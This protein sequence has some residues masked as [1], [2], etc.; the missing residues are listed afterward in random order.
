MNTDHLKPNTEE[1]ALIKQAQEN[2]KINTVLLKEV[3]KNKE[4]K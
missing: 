3:A 2:L 1:Q 4:K